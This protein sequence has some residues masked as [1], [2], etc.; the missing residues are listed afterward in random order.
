MP[1]PL[2]RDDGA[3]GLTAAADSEDL[4]TA[5]D[6]SEHTVGLTTVLLLVVSCAVLLAIITLVCVACAALYHLKRGRRHLLSGAISSVAPVPSVLVAPPHAAPTEVA[7]ELVES[8]VIASMVVPS[9]LT[10]DHVNLH[11]GQPLAAPPPY[12]GSPRRGRDSR[13][14]VG[15]YRSRSQTGPL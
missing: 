13:S 14:S 5:G 9:P 4:V 10:S 8:P 3:S 15:E 7:L 11:G 1:P 2:P 6:S 12:G